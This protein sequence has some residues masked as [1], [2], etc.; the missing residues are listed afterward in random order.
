MLSDAS[1]AAAVPA[2]R[3]RL[4][5][6]ALPPISSILFGS[7]QRLE[8]PQLRRR[9]KIRRRDKNASVQVNPAIWLVARSQQQRPPAES[10]VNDLRFTVRES[11]LRAT[12]RNVLVAELHKASG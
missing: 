8:N 11:V 5:R 7:D 1:S 3:R 10:A 6:A 4:R 9:D 12:P 2:V